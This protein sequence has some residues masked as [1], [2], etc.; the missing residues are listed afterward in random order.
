MYLFHYGNKHQFMEGI[1]TNNTDSE[2]LKIP[3]I[4]Y[5]HANK[6]FFSVGRWYWYECWR[7]DLPVVF[8][9][10][11]ACLSTSPTMYTFFSFHERLA[12][13]ELNKVSLASSLIWLHC[14]VFTFSHLLRQPLGP[15]SRL[16]LSISTH[17]PA[18]FFFWLWRILLPSSVYCWCFS[19][20]MLDLS[21]A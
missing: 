7:R 14:V 4:R 20:R 1:Q 16:P 6:L 19:S 11:T 17:S 15:S 10:I 18:S 21:V 5:V 8:L 3:V 2:N 12:Q 13:N 9:C